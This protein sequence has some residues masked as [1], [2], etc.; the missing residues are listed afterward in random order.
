M[1]VRERTA[2]PSRPWVEECES[3]VM[4][5]QGNSNLRR[6]REPQTRARQRRLRLQL[7]YVFKLSVMLSGWPDLN[8]V[9]LVSLER[10]SEFLLHARLTRACFDS[11]SVCRWCDFGVNTGDFQMRSKIHVP[12]G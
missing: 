4:R 5:P 6:V 10:T 7:P 12:I 1:R 3:R 8:R 9:T 2:R 11:L